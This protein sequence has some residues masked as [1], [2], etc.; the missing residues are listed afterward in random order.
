[1]GERGC[2]W[3]EVFVGFRDIGEEVVILGIRCLFLVVF[4]GFL[5]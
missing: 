3:K 4:G 2:G 1:M 5:M